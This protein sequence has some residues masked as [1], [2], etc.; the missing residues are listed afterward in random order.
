[1]TLWNCVWVGL[2]GLVALAGGQGVGREAAIERAR[3]SLAQVI[4]VPADR[5]ELVDS[6]ELEW[7]DSSLGCPARGMVYAPTLT[8]GFRVTFTVGSERF[9]VHATP[10]RAVV[11]GTPR[12]SGPDARDAK[13]PP[14][15]A[16]VGLRLSEQ[17]RID[18]ASRLHVE[19][20]HVTVKSFKRIV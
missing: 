19:K 16:V 11:C 5:I 17:A 8:A 15:D 10:E 4:A 9:V 12:A 3:A 14:A 13:L 18:L 6:V 2:L 1:M 20:E 7:R